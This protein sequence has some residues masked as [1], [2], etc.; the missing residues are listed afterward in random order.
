MSPHH[1]VI[2][3]G[4]FGGLQAA[5][6][7]RNA[8]LQ[9]TLIDKKNYHLFQP[10]LYQVATA[11]LSPGDI[12]S[13]LR[14]VLRT[15]RNT[16][17]L[18]GEVTDILPAEKL[19][20]LANGRRIPYDTL[21]VATGAGHHYFGN[22][23]WSVHAPGLKTIE[24]ATQIRKRIFLAFEKA[25][26]ER[27]AAVVGSL[28]TF[29]VIGGG[30]TGVEL[31]GALAEICKDTLRNDFRRIDPAASRIVLLEAAETVLPT[32]PDKLSRWAAKSLRKKG[33]TVKTGAKVKE[34]GEGY[35]VVVTGGGSE[36]IETGTVLWGAGVRASSLGN[37]L[38]EHT[39]VRLDRWG[40]VPVRGDL[41]LEGRSEIFVIGDLASCRD[42]SGEPLPGIA[43]V[44]LQQ[45][46]YLAR[47]LRRRLQ[48]KS[49][50][51]FRY[52]DRGIMATIGRASAVAVLGRLRFT[53][54]LA[55]LLWLFVHLLFLIEFQNRF[56]VL[57]QWAWN[58][59][60]FNRSARLITEYEERSSGRGS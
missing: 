41:S 35:V 6:S 39:G 15:H 23:S 21:I 42:S 3:G 43:P 58:Y 31:A 38:A 7:L 49:L 14:G 59:F 36:R 60:T 22:D 30:P 11:G 37:S 55:W 28:L 25:E 17:V 16:R 44:A 51:P 45:G 27:D 32:F 26:W 12:S 19:V 54:Y 18:L 13:P 20:V 48:G 56:L 24:D 57:V 40:R 52:R 2:V 53:G 5:R 34:V 8:P 50:P 4:G 1:V 29:V 46:S 33:V 9:V 10:L 47:L